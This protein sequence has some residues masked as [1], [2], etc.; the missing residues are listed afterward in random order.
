MKLSLS[1]VPGTRR[2]LTFI[3]V[4]CTLCIEKSIAQV[5][6]SESAKRVNSMV[7]QWAFGTIVLKNGEILEE[8]FAYNPLVPEGLLKVMIDEKI[9]VLS[10]IHV[11]EFSFFDRKQERLRK[12][13]SVAFSKNGY[14]FIEVLFLGEKLSLL[15]R[16]TIMI[17]QDTYNGAGKSSS[18]KRYYRL[19][20]FNEING[21]LRWFD[22][23][24]LYEK[25]NDR[26][27]EIK[28]YIKSQKLK[29]KNPNDV[30]DIFRY[31]NNLP[32]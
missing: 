27:S 6:H 26:K 18:T 24:S 23:K 22:K 1:D 17:Q 2:Y 7:E 28:D 10:P 19:V 8:K 15:G 20:I 21:S 9:R 3:I 32:Y 14:F 29:L 13:I 31:Y 30:I 11:A 4:V 12:F 16:E 25:M 5:M